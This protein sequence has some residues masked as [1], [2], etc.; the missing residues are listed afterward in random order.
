M[1]NEVNDAVVLSISKDE[2]QIMMEKAVQR[3]LED[4]GLYTE[5]AEDRRETREDLRFARR[6][7]KATDAG[8]ARIGYAVITILTGAALLAFWVGIMTHTQRGVP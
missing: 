6:M 3:G 1:R 2:L 7:R 4:I 8:A 5:S